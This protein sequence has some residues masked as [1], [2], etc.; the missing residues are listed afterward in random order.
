MECRPKNSQV[1][2]QEVIAVTQGRMGWLLLEVVVL[3]VRH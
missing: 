2:S 1:I 3:G